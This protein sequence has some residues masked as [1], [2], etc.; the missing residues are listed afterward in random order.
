MLSSGVWLVVFPLGAA[1]VPRAGRSQFD[2]LSRVVAVFVITRVGKSSSR[3][4]IGLERSPKM[5]NA[6]FRR[7]TVTSR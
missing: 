3:V 5:K 2:E 7:R 1:C 6:A 4:D